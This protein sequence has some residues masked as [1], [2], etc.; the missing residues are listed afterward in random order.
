MASLGLTCPRT[1]ASCPAGLCP[2][3]S[4]PPESGARRMVPITAR[5]MSTPLVPSFFP[6]GVDWAISCLLS[7]FLRC[8]SGLRKS[9]GGMAA[10]AFLGNHFWLPF[11]RLFSLLKIPDQRDRWMGET[12][13]GV[14]ENTQFVLLFRVTF[15]LS[16]YLVQGQIKG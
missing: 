2:V 12:C 13:P 15:S 9:Q 3:N 1:P 14:R 4:H 11:L 5:S 8:H 7:F 10:M 6:W 16:F